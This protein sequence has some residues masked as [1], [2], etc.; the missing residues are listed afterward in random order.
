VAHAYNSRTQETETGRLIFKGQSE[1]ERERE[2]MKGRKE[3]RREGKEKV[4]Q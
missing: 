4:F 3:R 1:R 2:K